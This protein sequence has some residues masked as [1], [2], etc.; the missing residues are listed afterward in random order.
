MK[1]VLERDVAVTAN[2]VNALKTPEHTLKIG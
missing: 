1:T 2:G